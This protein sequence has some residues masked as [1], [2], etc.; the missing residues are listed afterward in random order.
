MKTLLTGF[1]GFGSV[2]LNPSQLVVETRAE[3]ARQAGSNDLITE[4]LPTEFVQAGKRIVQLIRKFRPQRIVCLGVASTARTL[5]L[6]RVALNLDDG[7]QVDNAGL[8]L[9][10]KLIV[11]EGPPAYWSTLSLERMCAGLLERGIPAVISNHAG[12]YVCNHV[13][14]CA[15]H[16]VERLGSQATC[17]FIHLPP[18]TQPAGGAV[19]EKAAMALEL[20]IEAVELCLRQEGK[21]RRF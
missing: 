3:R 14:Y 11:G 15:R 17:G 5:R 18:L 4:V 20:M 12:T 2:L 1:N 21:E 9:K 7:E 10:G 8:I 19:T 6:E 16:E 13:F